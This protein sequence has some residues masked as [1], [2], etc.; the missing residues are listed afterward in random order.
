M[1]RFAT[2]LIALTT[3]AACESSPTQSV[4][5]PPEGTDVF[6]RNGDMEQASDWYFRAPAGM[7]AA[8][9]VGGGLGG[10]RGV[11]LTGSGS[12]ADGASAYVGQSVDVGDLS[13]RKVTL[14]AHLRLV[15]VNGAGV[16][17][18]LRGDALTGLTLGA[19]E[20]FSTT[21]GRVSI[22]GTAE[23]A[24]YSVDLQQL[25]ASIGTITAF[26]ILLPGT[27]GSV[28]V[29]D[30]KLSSGVVTLPARP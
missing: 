30:V 15:E 3:V 12:S 9:A 10:S 1:I 29:D 17:I 5:S 25:D 6:L 27:T 19:A 20:V 28:Y 8:Y 2:A 23:W 26:V 21:Q 11:K 4:T 16:A 7:S 13:G 24:V 22:R 14:T 18:A